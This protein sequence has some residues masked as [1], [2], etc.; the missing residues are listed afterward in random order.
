MIRLC[1]IIL[2]LFFLY[3]CIIF[4]HLLFYLWAPYHEC[5]YRAR[6]YGVVGA[7]KPFPTQTIVQPDLTRVG[8]TQASLLAIMLTC[9]YVILDLVLIICEHAS[10]CHTYIIYDHIS[11]MCH[12]PNIHHSIHH[13]I[14][15]SIHHNKSLC[16][17]RSCTYLV[18]YV[19]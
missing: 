2:L 14:H 3:S 16:C 11:T 18:R 1:F 8:T 12:N 5:L 15:H 9:S 13:N 19:Q 17:R 7:A 6:N 4:F 10:W